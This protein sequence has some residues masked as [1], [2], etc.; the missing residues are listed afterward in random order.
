TLSVRTCVP[1]RSVGTRD[2]SILHRAA[3]L[4]TNTQLGC[5]FD[6]PSV[7]SLTQ[8]LRWF[9]SATQM[10]QPG[11]STPGNS[12]SKF[13]RLFF[14]SLGPREYVMYFPSG[15]Q[16]MWYVSMGSLFST[17]LWMLVAF[18]VGPVRSRSATP[19]QKSPWPQ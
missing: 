15:D 4:L 7:V 10:S 12:G 8:R 14:V 16:V 19:A 13:L 5:L 9:A 6:L 17:T 18:G 11:A 1:T 2:K 3:L